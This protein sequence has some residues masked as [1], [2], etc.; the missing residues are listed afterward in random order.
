M[1]GSLSYALH[2]SGNVH[3]KE[4]PSRAGASAIGLEDLRS[5][6]LQ[7]V[8]GQAGCAFSRSDQGGQ[9]GL[10]NGKD[11]LY[12]PPSCFDFLLHISQ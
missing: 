5:D 4:R 2:L 11:T 12:G 8:S 10:V 7:R 9:Q 3:F 1:T 6:S